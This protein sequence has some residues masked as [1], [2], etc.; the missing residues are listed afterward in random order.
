[1]VMKTTGLDECILYTEQLGKNLPVVEERIFDTTS[2]ISEK[3]WKEVINRRGHVDSGCMRD[4]VKSDKTTKLRSGGRKFR[5]TYP[6]G[7]DYGSKKHKR[8][9][10]IRNAEKAFY[11]H[12]GKKGVGDHFVDEVDR[13]IQE[14]IDEPINKLIEDF[15]KNK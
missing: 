7:K 4:A 15:H 9:T 2:A 13:L 6:R 10:P 8:K 11:I 12:Y 1:M 5:D 3:C 14:R